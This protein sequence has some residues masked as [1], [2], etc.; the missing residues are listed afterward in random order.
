M[1][2]MRAAVMDAGSVAM[3]VMIWAVEKVATKAVLKGLTKAVLT[4]VK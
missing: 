1:V 2:A 3:M 4:V